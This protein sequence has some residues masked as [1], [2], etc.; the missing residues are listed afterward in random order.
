[1]D[2]NDFSAPPVNPLNSNEENNDHYPAPS[3]LPLESDLKTK[4]ETKTDFGD[5]ENSQNNNNNENNN[6]QV[7]DDEIYQPIERHYYYEIEKCRKI[8]QYIGCILLYGFS[9]WG[10]ILATIF[11]PSY[12]LIDDGFLIILASIMLYLTIK[13]RSTGRK[14]LGAVT[15]I[16]M[17]LGFAARGMNTFFIKKGIGIYIGLLA[18]RSI[19]LIYIIILNCNP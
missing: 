19:F 8:S 6:N 18:A 12:G 16:I 17:F 11:G 14:K 4:E 10:I 13:K 2:D 7:D 9:I 3:Q 15:L 5:N 1:M